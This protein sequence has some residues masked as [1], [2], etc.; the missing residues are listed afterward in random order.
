MKNKFKFILLCTVFFLLTGC[1]DEA[2]PSLSVHTEPIPESIEKT[3]ETSSHFSK[4]EEAVSSI[5]DVTE[6]SGEQ[7][8]NSD[9]E[10][11]SSEE[12]NED[13]PDEN[14]E[15]MIHEDLD[16]QDVISKMS[17]EEKVYQMIICTNEGLTKDRCSTSID[18]DFYND[19]LTHPVGGIIYF[20]KNLLDSSQTKE[21]LTKS[22]IIAKEISGFPL[23]TA[24]DEEGG[25][26]ARIGNN[27]GFDVTKVGPMADIK[28]EEEAFSAGN[29]IGGYLSELG[30]NLDFAP[31]A[32]VITTDLNT[33]IGNRSFGKDPG[34]VSLYAKAYSDG[35]HNNNVLSTYKHFP[36][37]GGTVGDTHE[38]YSYTDKSLDMM[39]DEELLPFREAGVNGIDAVMV[40]HISVPEILGSETPCSL[41]YEMITGILKEKCGYDGLII[42]DALNMGAVSLYGDEYTAVYAIKAGADILLMPMDIEVAA[43]SVISAVKDGSISEQRIDESVCKIL[44]VKSQF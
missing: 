28:S 40:A 43:N 15:L 37:H 23:F 18:S 12:L 11:S 42:T 25:I 44:R 30:F 24:I 6:I 22:Q 32:D 8:T 10:V 36:G 14:A 3:E 5:I 7:I 4:D 31:D 39:W 41:S 1:G 2:L 9:T 34:K 35:L 21:M 29:T 38:G 16:I 13:L 26:V 33:V 20:S 19:Y 27:A 17:L